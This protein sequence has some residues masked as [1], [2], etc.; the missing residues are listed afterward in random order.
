MRDQLRLY[1]LP[2]NNDLKSPLKNRDANEKSMSD[3]FVKF[4]T[5]VTGKKLK[6]PIIIEYFVVQVT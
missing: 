4:S 6:K 1:M 5:K 2:K 3:I